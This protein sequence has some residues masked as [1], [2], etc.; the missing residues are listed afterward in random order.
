M[1][2]GNLL[3]PHFISGVVGEGLVTMR[4]NWGC[5]SV[6]VDPPGD[7]GGVS[8]I[9]YDKRRRHSFTKPGVSNWNL[10]VIES[11]PNPRTC[12]LHHT[13]SL[14][15]EGVCLHKTIKVWVVFWFVYFQPVVV[16]YE[17]MKRKL[18]IKPTYEC[19][20]NGRLQTKRFTRLSH[21]G[22][23]TCLFIMNR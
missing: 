2:R 13:K 12:M 17:L 8:V 4:V 3:P 1:S 7:P 16:Y 20:C 23:K 5:H 15:F 14:N 11:V 21:T 22:L 6:T 9:R 10:F 19:R 18:K